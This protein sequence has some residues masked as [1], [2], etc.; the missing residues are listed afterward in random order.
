M[1][2]YTVCAFAL[3]LWVLIACTFLSV[4]IEEQMTAKVVVLTQNQI[5]R[6]SNGVRI[7]ADCL[8]YD[9]EGIHLFRVQA[10]NNVLQNG[11]RVEEVD[12]TAYGPDPRKADSLNVSFSVGEQ[13]IRYSSKPLQAGVPVA[14]LSVSERTDDI[15]LVS[16]P[17]GVPALKPLR[18]NMAVVEQG[19]NTLLLSVQNVPLPFMEDRAAGTISEIEDLTDYEGA[20]G[21]NG[22]EKRIYSLGAVEQFIQILPVLAVL[23]VML[24]IPVALWVYSCFLLRDMRKN[25]LLLRVNAVAAV[26][27]LL[28]LLPVLGAVDLPSSLLPSAS[29]LDFRYYADEF[30]QI[31]GV[32]ARLESDPQVRHLLD[33]MSWARLW[34]VAVIAAGV[35]LAAVLI[36][37]EHHISR[38]K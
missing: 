31:F 9:S 29:I 3:I 13:V 6:V 23:L 30:E 17:G 25:S 18:G 20:R 37:A 27:S 22:A 11:L 8:F 34:A 15:Y 38:R 21:V 4:R 26:L 28:G 24:L 7:P 10:V 1:K 14:V 5:S 2:K 16:Y 19:E 33:G 32:L 12:E 35:L 36:V